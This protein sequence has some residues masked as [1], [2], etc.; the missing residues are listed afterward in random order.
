MVMRTR[1]RLDPLRLL[2]IKRHIAQDKVVG[3]QHVQ[4]NTNRLALN[5]RL[6]GLTHFHKLLMLLAMLVTC[7]FCIH[8][9]TG[10]GVVPIQQL[11]EAKQGQQVREVY[12]TRSA[13]KLRWVDP[14][15]PLKQSFGVR[16][17]VRTTVCVTHLHTRSVTIGH[18]F[19]FRG[20]KLSAR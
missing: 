1:R 7:L 8:V 20:P 11:A 14:D 5:L 16:G 12:F 13:M 9:L 3:M 17:I 19:S 18:R 6:G 10:F 2:G 4:K 15:G